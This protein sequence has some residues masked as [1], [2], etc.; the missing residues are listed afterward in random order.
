MATRASSSDPRAE[1]VRESI[2]AAAL[3]SVVETRIEDVSVRA[4]V[5]RAGV[6]RP[7]FYLHFADRDAAVVAA[8]TESFAAAVGDDRGRGGIEDLMRYATSN[9][10]LYRNLY[11]GVASQQVAQAFRERL[12]PLCRDYVRDL[13]RRLATAGATEEEFVVDFLAGGLMEVIMSWMAGRVTTVSPIHQTRA[14]LD[15]LDRLLG[16]A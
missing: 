5:D 15:A 8:L 6:S 1:R 2:K 7:A 12:R 14:M 13:R 10:T 4:I 16:V 9:V 11:P 3:E